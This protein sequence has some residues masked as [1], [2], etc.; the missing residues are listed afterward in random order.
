MSKKRILWLFNHSSL[1][2][3]E[4]PLLVKMGYEV[5]CPKSYDFEIGDF[6]CTITYEYDRTLTIPKD[7]LE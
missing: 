5:Y 6:S 4:V 7:V 2:S 1:R 3:F